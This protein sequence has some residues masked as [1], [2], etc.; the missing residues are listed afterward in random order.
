MVTPLCSLYMGV[1]KMNSPIAQTL[2]QY[3]TL[4]EY[5]AYNWS[6]GQFCD[7]WPILAKRWLSWQRPLDACNQKCLLWIGQK[8][9]SP[10]ISNHILAISH[11]NAFIRIYSNF[12]PKSGCRDN[13][14][15]SL[16]HGSVID[17]FHD[18]TNPISN[19][20]LN[21]YVAYNWSYGHFRVFGLFC[22]NFGCHGNAT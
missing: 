5:V 15:L 8:R 2:S 12:S 13:A 11:R 4:H 18:A 16:V 22:P 19:Q 9:K 20:T 21:G 17:E 3:Q 6:Y 7:F 1:S 10:V 14:P